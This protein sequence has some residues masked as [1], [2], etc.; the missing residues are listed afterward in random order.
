M[1][2]IAE[3]CHGTLP[4]YMNATFR[5]RL[6]IIQRLRE[7]GPVSRFRAQVHTA[8]DRMLEKPGPALVVAT[9]RALARNDATLIAAGVAFYALLSLFPLILGLL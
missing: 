5:D 1:E 8:R 4:A 3:Q 7:A 6:Q 9:G 2:H